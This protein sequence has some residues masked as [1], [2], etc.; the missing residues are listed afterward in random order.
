MAHAQGNGRPKAPRN[1]KTPTTAVSPVSTVASGASTHPQFGSW[2]DDASARGRGEGS[3]SIGAGL[4]RL[5]GMTQRNIPMVGGD[6]GISDRMQVSA[7]VPFYRVSTPTWSANGL[8]DVYVSAKYVVLDPAL[9]VS[10]VG[11]AI[12][13]VVEILS[14]DTTDGRVHFALPV[15]V[16][17]RRMPFRIYGSAGY[18]T[19]GALFGGAALEWTSSSGVSITGAML[20]SYSLETASIT[21]TGSERTHADLSAGVAAPVAPRMSVYGSVGRS[22]TSIESGGA[23]ISLTGGVSVRFNAASRVP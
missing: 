22:L 2:L 15:S 9:T 1:S 7:S 11:V 6:I 14:A 3:V 19:R 12:S 4:W 17:L 23:S 10:E 16:E 18:F 21:T 20:Q 8:D 5:D 13:P